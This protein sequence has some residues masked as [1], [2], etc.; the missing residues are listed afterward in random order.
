MKRRLVDAVTHLRERDAV[1]RPV[2]DAAGPCVLRT[3]RDRFR[4]LVRSII[5]QQLSSAAART[6]AARLYDRVGAVTPEA[7]RS[8]T[9]EEFRALGISSQK[10]SYLRDLAARVDSGALRLDDLGRFSDEVV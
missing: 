10:E 5:G 7:L 8:L 2:I 1:L 9:T 6:I 4:M 3:E